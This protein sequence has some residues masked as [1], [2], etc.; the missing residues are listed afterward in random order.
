M[1]MHRRG[2]AHLDLR[3]RRNVLILEDGTPGVIDF[4]TCVWLD[5]LPRPV[6]EWLKQVDLSG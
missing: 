4:Q 2:I 1:E 3:Y 6:R 5:R